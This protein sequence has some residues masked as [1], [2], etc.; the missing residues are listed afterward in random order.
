VYFKKKSTQKIKVEKTPWNKA[1]C[2][3]PANVVVYYIM[4]IGLQMRCDL[5]ERRLHCNSPCIS[6]WWFIKVFLIE[7]GTDAEGYIIKH[8]LQIA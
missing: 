5:C 2:K 8:N 7:P 1:T 6:W 4:Y 3:T